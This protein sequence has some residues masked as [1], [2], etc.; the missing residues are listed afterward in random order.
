MEQGGNF[1]SSLINT[2]TFFLLGLVLFLYCALTSYKK[3]CVELIEN[4]HQQWINIGELTPEVKVHWREAI[5]HYFCIVCNTWALSIIWT[6]RNVLF[7]TLLNWKDS[8]S[9][10]S[11]SSKAVVHDCTVFCIVFCKTLK[12]LF[13]LNAWNE[14][15]VSQS[16]VYFLSGP[17]RQMCHSIASFLYITITRCVSAFVPQWWKLLVF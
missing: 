4:K 11:L 10:C 14:H 3:G 1:N 12:W 8:L 16:T 5:L 7:S 9:I 2:L 6:Y 17:G 15:Q 13:R